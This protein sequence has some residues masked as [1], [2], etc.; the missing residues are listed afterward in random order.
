MMA[1]GLHVL[2]GR[3]LNWRTCRKVLNSKFSNFHE[4]TSERIPGQKCR[5][6]VYLVQTQCP[7]KNLCLS[8]S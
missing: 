1:W 6:P 3:G 8:L 7:S 4:L 5:P 2:G